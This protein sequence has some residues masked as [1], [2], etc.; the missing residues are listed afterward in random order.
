MHLIISCL[1]QLGQ[2]NAAEPFE[3]ATFFLHD[4][5]TAFSFGITF[6]ISILFIKVII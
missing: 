4:E 1:L 6:R 3:F 5:H 2:L